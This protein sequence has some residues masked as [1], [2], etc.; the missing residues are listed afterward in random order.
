M[1]V[2]K[3]KVANGVEEIT[4]EEI[5]TAFLNFIGISFSKIKRRFWCRF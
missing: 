3:T 4:N 5:V 2:A 1:V